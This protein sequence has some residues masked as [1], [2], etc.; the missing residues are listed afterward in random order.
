MRKA[1]CNINHNS[2]PYLKF[3][4]YVDNWMGVFKK[5]KRFLIT[6]S[7]QAQKAVDCIMGRKDNETK[8][9]FDESK[10]GSMVS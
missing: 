4:F 8:E 2:N 5:D 10:E 9:E 6:A 3:I 1:N 7:G